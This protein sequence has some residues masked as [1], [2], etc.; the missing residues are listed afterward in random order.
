MSRRTFTDQQKKN[1]FQKL[2]DFNP[3]ANDQKKVDHKGRVI[4]WT[5]YGN[6]NSTYGWNIDHIN[7]NINDNSLNNLRAVHYETH[8]ELNKRFN[9]TKNK[10]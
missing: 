8:E 2:L 4:H 10:R 9:A 5:Q 7:R 3:G 1:V 6:R